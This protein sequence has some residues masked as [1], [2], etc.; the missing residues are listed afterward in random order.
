MAKMTKSKNL[1][2]ILALA[3]VL[4]QLSLA[5]PVIERGQGSEIDEIIMKLKQL[6]QQSEG[7]NWKIA[8]KICV[9]VKL[10]VVKN[11]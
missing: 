2:L 8:W 4:V 11:G 1:C 10:V 5:A 9:V 3:T 7:K 6:K